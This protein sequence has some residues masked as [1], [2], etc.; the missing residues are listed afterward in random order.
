MVLQPA[1]VAGRTET[2]MVASPA[3]VPG[4][5]KNQSARQALLPIGLVL[6]ISFAPFVGYN[7]SDGG[8]RAVLMG[9]AGLTVLAAVLRHFGSAR[10]GLA[11]TTTIAGFGLPWQV[12]WWPLPGALGVCAYVLCHR[13]AR[14]GSDDRSAW[15]LGRLTR[16]DAWAIVGL[17]M[18]SATVLLAFHNLTAPNL[19]FGADLVTEV[20]RWSLIA[21]AVLFASTNAAVEELLFRGAILHHLRHA[22]G[23][24]PAVTLQAMAFGLLHLHGYPYGP[25][26]VV[27]ATLYGL[28]LG[29]VRIRSGGLLGPWV[30]HVCADLVIFVFILQAAPHA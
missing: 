16:A 22:L 13:T 28:L 15:R 14:D 9:L 19:A 8:G 29:A 3:S 6:V 20:P 24:W 11:L 2:S 7:P 5:A 10:L 4:A 30:A 23:P 17:V 27:L 21:V 18:L 25:V 26:G 1:A 12:S